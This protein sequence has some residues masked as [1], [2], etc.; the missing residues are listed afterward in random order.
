[1]S[2][3]N[4]S[5][6]L[7]TRLAES[8]IYGWLHRVA[9]VMDKYHLDAVAGLI[10][11]GMGDIVT[12]LISMVFVYV[13]AFVVKST[14]LSI[15][16]LNNI[17]RDLMLGLIPFYVGDVIDVFHRSNKQNIR[18]VEGYVGG[19]PAVINEVN[20]RVWQSLAAIVLMLGVIV[21][22]VWIVAKVIGSI[23]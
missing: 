15:A 9:T 12:A 4:Q 3:M 16:L 2:G 10:P 14:A 18:L 8:R 21:L 22:L 23:F 11:G 7:S 6:Q 5:K 20:S 19:D 17:V 13:G 1:M